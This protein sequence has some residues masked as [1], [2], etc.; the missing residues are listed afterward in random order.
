MGDTAKQTVTA[1]IP[2][3]AAKTTATVKYGASSHGLRRGR[4][5]EGEGGTVADEKYVDNNSLQA[6]LI[7]KI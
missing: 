5:P 3:L 1:K 6:R 7:F 2:Q 4:Y